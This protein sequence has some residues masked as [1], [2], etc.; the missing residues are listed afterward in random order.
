MTF[1]NYVLFI[2]HLKINDLGSILPIVPFA[3]VIILNCIAF[4]ENT[5]KKYVNNFKKL[6]DS[7]IMR[8]KNISVLITILILVNFV[9]SMII[10]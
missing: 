1:Y 2:F 5:P 4:V 7:T 8:A 10:R 3:S 9:I 6:P